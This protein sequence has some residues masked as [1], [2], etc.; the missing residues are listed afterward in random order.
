[1]LKQL[2]NER[3]F[4]LLIFLSLLLMLTM[5]G[6]AGVMT[7]TTDVDIA[8]NDLKS[9][10][11][12]YAAEAGLEKAVSEIRTS[13]TTTGLP[14][15]PLPGCTFNLGN[16]TVTY[17]T[18]DNGPATQKQ[19]TTGAYRGLYALVKSF[20]VTAD[21]S[22]TGSGAATRIVQEVEDALIPLFQ[23]AI[24]YEDDLEIYPGPNMTLG[25]R[26][27][28]N[29]NMYLGTHATL[30]IDSYTT[31]ARNIY[32]GRKPGSG[33]GLGT[34]GN[35]NI[36]DRDGVYQN[37]KN[38]DGTY[39]DCT[40]PDWVSESLARWGG[41]VE[42]Q[43]HGITE[44]NLP[45][46]TSGD[47][48]DLIKRGADNP[49]SLEHDAGLKI[50]DGLAWYR[51]GSDTY[52]DVTA[53]LTGDSTL[54]TNTFYNSREGKWVT[55]YDID[56]DRLNDS[57]YY[58]L[59]G[60]VY[61]SRDQV[62]GTEQTIRLVNGEELRSALTVAT[63]NPLYTLGDYNTDNKKPAALYIDALT[64]LSNNW[65]DSK[66][67]LSLGNRIASNTTVNAAFMT[68]NTNSED[69]H[70][71]GGLENL[72]RFLENWTNKTFTY[73]GSMVDLWFSEQATGLWSY[74]S[75]YTAPWRNW[76]FDLDFLDPTNLPPGTPMVNAVQKVS[77][78]QKIVS[79]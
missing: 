69:S 14:P 7:S 18:V 6:I 63:D 54:T 57:P 67:N 38:G 25:G 72:P 39:L 71:S 51:T 16:L 35:I 64:I 20:T 8:G 28:T 48:I 73:K 19:L 27:H 37:M 5:I 9:I 56:I 68:G 53:S 44:L 36:N 66:S 13:Y 26:V 24:F 42:D 17:N 1:M 31:A 43:A 75:Y 15:S 70:Y 65:D 10:S 77:W 55:S 33:Q 21:A 32:Y 22:H 41:M 78:L 60:I 59:N 74:G 52:I 49:S 34:E 62:V 3:G 79:N 58:P 2:K 61:A 30:S 29:K 76:S 46:V 12:L 50:V 40:D 45:V 47:P 23:F 4:T 11:A